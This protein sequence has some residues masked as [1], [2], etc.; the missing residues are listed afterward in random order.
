MKNILFSSLFVC[1]SLVSYSQTASEVSRNVAKRQAMNS[2]QKVDGLL[3]YTDEIR[4]EI[5]GEWAYDTI[6]Y[7]DTS[8]LI[9][10]PGENLTVD[11]TL[12]YVDVNV[13][14]TVTND[15]TT[16]KFFIKFDNSTD[17]T[18]LTAILNPTINYSGYIFR[19]AAGY[20]YIL[21][22]TV[23]AGNSGATLTTRK[24]GTISKVANTPM[25]LR[26]WSSGG[27][28]VASYSIFTRASLL[29]Q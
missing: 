18:T 10:F 1:I 8:L 19:T 7:T 9:A 2:G 3:N 20:R 13:K 26:V 11:R 21:T 24:I 6:A 27:S 17:S 23:I 15:T 25:K 16:S 22:E 14:L 29:K 5:G 12:Y 4:K 28:E